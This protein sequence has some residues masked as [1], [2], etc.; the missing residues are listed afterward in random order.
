MKRRILRFRQ[1][2]AAVALA[3][4]KVSFIAMLRALMTGQVSK[5]QWRQ[6]MRVC[7]KCPVYDPVRKLCRREIGAPYE[8]RYGVVYTEPQVIGCGCYT[9]YLAR[10]RAPY[11]K[12]AI[13]WD[14]GCEKRYYTGDPEYAWS[15][16]EGDSMVKPLTFSSDEF[17]EI[18]AS[19]AS[20][21]RSRETAAL[22]QIGGCWGRAT[23]GGDFG[24]GEKS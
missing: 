2:L 1:W 22:V 24:W 7:M 3:G 18:A 12:F 10:T 16:I 21:R 6:R 8:G 17:P 20:A 15:R 13:E 19:L 14:A 5:A 11:R 4:G 9:P 23:M